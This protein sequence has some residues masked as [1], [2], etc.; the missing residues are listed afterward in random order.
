M[1]IAINSCYGGFDLSEKAYSRMIE[2]GIPV[3]KYI[4][5]DDNKRKDE[6]V[7]FEGEGEM[8]KMFGKYW[9]CW[10]KRE[11]NRTNKI[12]IK[13]IEELGIKASGKHGKIKVVEIPD[14][15]EWEIQEYDGIESIHEKHRSWN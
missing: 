3:K 4:P 2:L 8:F 10:T 7:I 12:L 9:E 13:V 15:V 11:E 6:K 14:N 1:K 5:D